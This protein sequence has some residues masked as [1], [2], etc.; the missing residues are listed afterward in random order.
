MMLFWLLFA[1]GSGYVLLGSLY[2]ARLKGQSL[3]VK[4]PAQAKEVLAAHPH[5]ARWAEVRSLTMDGVFFT[6]AKLGLSSSSGGRKSYKAVPSVVDAVEGEDRHGSS[7]SSSSGGKD[8][9]RSGHGTKEGKASKS[10]SSSASRKDKKKSSKRSKPGGGEAEQEEQQ[11][12]VQVQQQQQQE[13]EEKQR[14]LQEKREGGVH[15]S[16]QKIKVVGLN[17]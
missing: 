12:E 7:S 3:K 1:G 11:E 16:Q 5:Y 4:S 8:R 2:G 15:S 17:G 9:K 10:S 6:R 13:E 14:L